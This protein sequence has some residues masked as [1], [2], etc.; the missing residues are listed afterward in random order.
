L[1]GLALSASLTLPAMAADYDLVML[2]GRVM[3]P[4]T[5]LDAKLNVGVKDGMIAVITTE[6]ITGKETIDATGHVVA[7]GMVDT[8]F[9]SLDGLSMK[10]AATDGVTTGMDLEM[11]SAP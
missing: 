9:H 4:E 7:P 5:M 1:L 10:M 3:G 6:V 8:H 11:R 2:N